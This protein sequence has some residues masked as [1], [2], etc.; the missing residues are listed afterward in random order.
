MEFKVD[1]L[2]IQIIHLLEKNAFLSSKEIGRRL[3]RSNS[4]IAGR[5]RRLQKE[6][7]IVRYAAI[8]DYHKISN[9]LISF[10][11]VRISNH[12]TASLNGFKTQLSKFDEVIECE[13][14]TGNY[15]FII[16]VAVQ[17]MPAYNHFIN[18]KL[19]MMSCLAEVLSL[20]VLEEFKRETNYPIFM[21]NVKNTPA[22]H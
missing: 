10:I 7:V 3:S 14:I 16:K 11:L 12:S 15:D 1:H 21:F 8:I 13:H 2:D 20:P 9:L 5:I 17:H 19:G 22:N 18:K 6:H 4:V